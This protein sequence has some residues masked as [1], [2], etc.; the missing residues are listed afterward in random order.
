MHETI[1]AHGWRIEDEHTKGFDGGDDYEGLAIF[2]HLE[3]LIRHRFHGALSLSLKALIM[4][5]EGLRGVRLYMAC[6]G[7]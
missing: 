5:F 4:R 3:V 7:T 6:V 1:K 2:E